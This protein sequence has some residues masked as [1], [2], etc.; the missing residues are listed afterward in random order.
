[1]TL[2]EIESA[3]MKLDVQSRARLARKLILSLEDLSVQENLALWAQESERRLQELRADPEQAIDADAAMIEAR[4][5][6]E[7]S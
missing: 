3:I 6:L 4:R 1:M 2:E 7:N 5:S